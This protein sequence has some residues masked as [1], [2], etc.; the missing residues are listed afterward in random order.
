[1]NYNL[2]IRYFTTSCA[3][4]G[5]RQDLIKLI[6]IVAMLFDHL[7]LFFFEDTLYLR[8]VGRIC[9]PIFCFC[10]GYN[11]KSAKLSLLAAGLIT[12]VVTKFCFGYAYVNILFGIFASQILVKRVR[13]NKYLSLATFSLCCFLTFVSNNYVEYGLLP[14]CFVLC[15]YLARKRQE[16]STLL[17]ISFFVLL[18]YSLVKFGF[19]SILLFFVAAEFLLCYVALQGDMTKAT[20]VKAAALIA[21]NL[22]PIYAI[23]FN[24]LVIFKAL[25]LS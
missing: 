4:Y 24:A 5:N 9:M 2:T 11:L 15:G 23:H 22:L 16:F 20:N 12:L 21:R 3:P 14:F 10:A 19:S 25:L 17:A 6:A 1:M 7:G 18:Y 13:K 8:G